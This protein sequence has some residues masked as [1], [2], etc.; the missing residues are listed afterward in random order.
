[1]FFFSLKNYYKK[2]KEFQ[3]GANS[4][5]N[6]LLKQWWWEHYKIDIIPYMGLDVLYKKSN[7]SKYHGEVMVT[8][9]EV[10]QETGCL[11]P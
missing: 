5:A 6:K 4:E 9:G 2:K 1:M 10:I 3:N 11:V 8:T 7:G